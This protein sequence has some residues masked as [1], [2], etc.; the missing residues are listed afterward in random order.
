MKQL[1]TLT[2]MLNI[3]Y[4]AFSFEIENASTCSEPVV[5]FYNAFPN[6]GNEGLN[7]TT[8]TNHTSNKK[9][10]VTFY[11]EQNNGVKTVTDCVELLISEKN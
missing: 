5:N 2:V 4:T 1:I 6:I 9:T 10:L 8:Y 11:V 3:S 7:V